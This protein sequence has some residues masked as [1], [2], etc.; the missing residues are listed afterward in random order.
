MLL[1]LINTVYS[2][3]IA[4]S[5]VNSCEEFSLFTIYCLIAELTSK[6]HKGYIIKD[7]ALIDRKLRKIISSIKIFLKNNKF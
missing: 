2:L 6:I 5:Q 7:F 1:L 4:S 3:N